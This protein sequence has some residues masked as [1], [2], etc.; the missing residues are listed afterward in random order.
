MENSPPSGRS[1][2]PQSPTPN[3]PKQSKLM[4]I[5]FPVGIF[6][7]FSQIFRS[8]SKNVPLTTSTT[9]WKAEFRVISHMR[10]D[11]FPSTNG[12]AVTDPYRLRPSWLV[13]PS[14][15]TEKANGWICLLSDCHEGGSLPPD[16]SNCRWLA[17]PRGWKCGPSDGDS[18]FATQPGTPR[19]DDRFSFQDTRP[20]TGRSFV[21]ELLTTYLP[22]TVGK[23]H[24]VVSQLLSTVHVVRWR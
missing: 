5:V 4:Q 2:K 22:P 9:K 8:S 17:A 10:D 24:R 7:K 23:V 1:L 13:N 18:A 12:G 19:Q 6:Q 14:S 11:Y 15:A 20:T 21:F 3:I 16:R